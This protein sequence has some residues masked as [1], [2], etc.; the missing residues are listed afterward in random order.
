[1]VVRRNE[2]GLLHRVHDILMEKDIVI[3]PCDTMYGVVG[4]APETEQRIADLKNREEGKAFLQLIGD[5][6]WLKRFTDKEMPESLKV[7]WPG[8]LTVIFPDKFN[9]TVALRVPDDKFLKELLW[10]LNRPLFSTS[11]NRSGEKPLFRIGEIIRQFND[12]VDLIID[13]GDYTNS[14]PSTIVDVTS[15]DIR[16]V[17]QGCIVL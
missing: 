2:P 1:M 12:K 8:P 6:S 15:S 14:V 3:M 4:I 11:V 16:L 13:S 5:I 10:V 17:R 9:G 7:H